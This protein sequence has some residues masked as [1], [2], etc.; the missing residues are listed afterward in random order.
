VK[1]IYKAVAVGMVGAL[2]MATMPATAHAEH[3][4]DNDTAVAVIAGV[5]TVGIIAA[6]ASSHHA[7]M[8][9]SYNY[10]AS[11][12]PPRCEPPPRFIGGHYEVRR[13]RVVQPGHWETVVEPAQYGWVRRGHHH[14]YVVVKPECHQRVWVPERCDWVETRVWV[15]GHYEG[16][17]Y[18][19]L[20][21]WEARR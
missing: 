9:V 1:A 19:E 18:A 5:A 21:N 13:E 14:V 6:I 3:R 17:R 15:P 8:Y 4:R 10:R 11:A 20:R 16:G 12:P 7:D 2:V